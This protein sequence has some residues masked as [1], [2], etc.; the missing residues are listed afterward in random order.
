MKTRKQALQQYK[1]SEM[2]SDTE[3]EPL[4]GKLAL[5]FI[6]LS[7][8]KSIQNFMFDD[9]EEVASKDISNDQSQ[10]FY[11]KDGSV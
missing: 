7:R 8:L 6:I 1:N 4:M 3:K 9:G 5:L 11:G 10:A 2:A